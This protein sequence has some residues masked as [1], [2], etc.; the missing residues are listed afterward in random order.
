ME[1]ANGF[2]NCLRTFAYLGIFQERTTANCLTCM[3]TYTASCS[4]LPRLSEAMLAYFD[5]GNNG[6]QTYKKPF[7][8]TASGF[9][10]ITGPVQT[11]IPAM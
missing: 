9:A 2:W 1:L 11:F 6:A 8:A 3:A 7:G 5:A 4:A 10:L